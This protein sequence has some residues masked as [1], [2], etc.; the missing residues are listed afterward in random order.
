MQ[1]WREGH[2]L[3][4]IKPRGWICNSKREIASCPWWDVAADKSCKLFKFWELCSRLFVN[5]VDN[6]Q[7]SILVKKIEK[8]NIFE[9]VNKV[10]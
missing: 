7:Y 9:N 5:L 8:K 1:M 2:S 3:E 10:I 6:L 4:E